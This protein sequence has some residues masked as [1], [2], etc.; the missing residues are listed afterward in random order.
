MRNKIIVSLLLSLI[1]VLP[2]STIAKEKVAYLSHTGGFW[3]VWLMN[4][5]GNSKK[6]V[7]SS[8]YDKS[9]I[10]WYPDGNHILV[11]GNQGQLN[12]VNVTTK[13]EV[14]IDL[15]IKG[16]VD[17]VISPDGQHIAFSLSVAGSVDN[18]HIWVV[19]SEGNDLIKLTNKQGLQHEPVWSPNGQWIYF[20]SGK[21]LQTHDIW[22]VSTK[23]KSTEQLTVNQLYHFDLS[24]SHS[25]NMVFSSNRSGNYEIWLRDNKG[26]EYAVT[27][28]E[29]VDSR[30]TISLN[31]DVV[32]F[33]S[34]RGGVMDIWRKPVNGKAI[35]LTQEAVGAR[36]PIWW[37]G[38]ARG[39]E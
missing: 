32:I 27:Q 10:S 23:T 31:G 35:Q 4:S 11:N 29:A 19:N 25:G 24:F 20:L 18:N 8:A 14:P 30:P 39:N 26:K 15:P 3:Q 28:H 17:A 33:E 21:G 34:A 1:L 38:K 36:Y 22:R 16:T 7:T 37:Q 9:H 2:V 6:Q 12:K 13:V 5:N